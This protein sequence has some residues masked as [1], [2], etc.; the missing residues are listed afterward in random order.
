MNQNSCEGLPS[1][2]FT[3]TSI[4]MDFYICQNQAYEKPKYNKNCHLN[5]IS[6]FF[7]QLTFKQK[8]E[9]SLVDTWI[10]AKLHKI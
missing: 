4:H 5:P 8:D 1:I 10:V 7:N 3:V 6:V 2:D 9:I